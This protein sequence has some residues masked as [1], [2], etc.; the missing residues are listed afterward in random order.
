[1]IM[2]KT[3]DEIKKS[4]MSGDIRVCVIGIGRIGLPTALSIAKSGL[5]TTGVDINSNLVNKIHNGDFPLKDEPGYEEIFNNVLKKNL[6]TATT[7]IEE[8][9]PNCD[10][11][12]MSLPTPMDD[13]NVPDYSA[14]ISVG[15]QLNQLISPKSLIVVES[16]IEPGFVETELI[17]ILENSNRKLTAGTDF[18]IGVCPETANPGEILKD[19]TKLP[20]LVGGIDE[21]TTNAIMAIYSHI[22]PVE[23]VKMTNC[24]T[25]NAVKLTTNVFRDLN[26]AFVNELSLLFEKLGIDTFQVLDAAKRKYN[27]QIHY[28]G[29]GVGGP[30]LPVN[31]YQILNSAKKID[32]ELLKLVKLGCEINEKMPKHV[33]ELT[34]DA[35]DEKNL[36]IANSKILILGISYKPD[37]K[38]IQLAPAEHVIKLL[39]DLGAHVTIFDPYFKNSQVFD[40]VCENS[41]EEALSSS[42]AALIITAH[43]EFQSIDPVYLSSK[44]LSRIL[45]DSRGLIDPIG[46]KNAGLVFRGIGRFN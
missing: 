5:P 20:R 27:F 41:L 42:D 33:V 14:L 18:S 39:K 34:L 9:V 37:V 10:V 26:I 22:F 44:L 46:A 40:I 35:F 8:A 24:K 19:F 21:Q 23:L 29:A 6:F 4:L 30:C 7:K 13:E 31:A 45:I 38:D 12:L 36:K 16:T 15:K 17:P 2:S 11:I 32:P 3:L 43:K 1:M 25:A 28:P